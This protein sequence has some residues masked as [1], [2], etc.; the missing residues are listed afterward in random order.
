MENMDRR[1]ATW[2]KGE[3]PN[4]AQMEAAEQ[5]G[6]G[7][8]TC[9]E[10]TFT[11]VN[12]NQVGV[13]KAFCAFAFLQLHFFHFRVLCVLHCV[14]HLHFWCIHDFHFVCIV[15]LHLLFVCNF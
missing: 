2:E 6:Q 13:R 3:I 10:D 12:V 14:L 5:P 7:S 15:F 9:A 4:A 8:K 11:P 1:N